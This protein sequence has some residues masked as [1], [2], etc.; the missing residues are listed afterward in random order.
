MFKVPPTSLLV[1]CKLMGA[2]CG[3]S[4]MFAEAAEAVAVFCPFRCAVTI[5]TGALFGTTEMAMP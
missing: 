3:G 5:V 4:A 1:V 2:V